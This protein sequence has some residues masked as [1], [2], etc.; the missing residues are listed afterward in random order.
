MI[1][2][3][4]FY[5]TSHLLTLNEHYNNPVCIHKTDAVEVPTLS[6]NVDDTLLSKF[7]YHKQA[8]NVLPEMF[9]YKDLESSHLF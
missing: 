7:L 5:V 2:K 9:F 8:F 6:E 1:Y 4:V 3:Y